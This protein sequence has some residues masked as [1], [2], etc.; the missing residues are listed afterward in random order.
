MRYP[1]WT[2]SLS[3]YLLIF[4]FGIQSKA[5]P[6]PSKNPSPP[7]A[8][9]ALKF[10]SA[11]AQKYV[12]PQKLPLMDFSISQTY[13]G[14]M[15]LSDKPDETE[16][17][18]FWFVPTENPAAAKNLALWTNGG[19]GCSSLLGAFQ[20]NGPI[21]WDQGKPKA[22]KNP[23]SWSQASSM[24]Y[25]EHPVNV[26]FSTGKAII[27]NENQVAE[28]I[29][30][31]LTNF[32]K[33]FP[34]MNTANFYLTGESYA[35]MYLS[36]AAN[37]IYTRQSELAL[38]LQGVLFIDPVLASSVFQE[39]LPLYPFVKMNEDVFK[40]NATFMKQL[41]SAHN[42]CGYAAFLDKFYK[43]PVPG[44]FPDITNVNKDPKCQ[45]WRRMAE[46]APDGLDI[47]N[48]H[49][50]DGGPDPLDSKHN[51]LNR[52]D[53][54][55][56]LNV[57][58]NAPWERCSNHK[59]IFPNGDSSSDPTDKVL[60]DIITKGKRTIVAHGVLDGRLPL[61]GMSVGLQGMTWA[62]KQGFQKPIDADF[63]VA[64]KPHGKFRTERGLTFVQV[65]QAGHMIPHDA[66]EAALSIFEYLLGNRPSL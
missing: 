63:M 1:T 51:Y 30:K 19:P 65:A 25:L 18:F 6:P 10:K 29:F 11:A 59:N 54:R 27:S 40:F 66:P 38:K 57:A 55:K 52:P 7:A 62:G 58:S 20:E 22:V 35:G 61:L 17:L 43:Y 60:P 36:Y 16:Q 2:H 15:K 4:A 23:N 46:A 5:L 50:K 39:D 56:A 13:A 12:V 28:Y 33:I 24:L 31:F 8:G 3:A 47:Y 49:H 41:E 42:S 14:L 21:M 37:L 64:G 32:L 53:V 9:S 45:L 44:R 26:G 48:I 34:E